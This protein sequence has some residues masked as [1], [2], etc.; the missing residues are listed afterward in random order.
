MSSGQWTT[1]GLLILLF[2]LEAVRIP[3][4]KNWISTTYTALGG[5]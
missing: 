4:L 5:K 1:I 2:A 3:A